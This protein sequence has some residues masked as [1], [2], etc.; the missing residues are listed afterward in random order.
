MSRLSKILVRAETSSSLYSLLLISKILSL[1]HDMMDLSLQSYSP[2][3]LYR[4]LLSFVVLHN[5]SVTFP[6]LPVDLMFEIFLIWQYIFTIIC[7]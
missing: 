4:S 7:K 2:Q 1:C 6:K 3:R 5:A